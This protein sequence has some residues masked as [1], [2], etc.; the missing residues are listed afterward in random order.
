M[1]ITSKL[2][3]G[4]KGDQ[5]REW[6]KILIK[7]GF[8]LSPWYDDGDFGESTHN[9]TVAWQSSHGLE[10]NGIVGPETVAKINAITIPL[11]DPFSE[12]LNIKFI[13][14]KNYQKA[15][16]NQISL[17]VLHSEEAPESSTTALNVANWFAGNNA[18]MASAHFCLD[19]RNIIQ[20][21]KEE[22][23]AYHAL[24]ANKFSI[25]IEHA[26]Y[27]RQTEEQWADSFSTQMLKRSAKLTASL[28]KKWNI[29]VKYIDV[30]GLINK[31]SGITTHA[32]C[33]KAYKE[34]SHTDPGEHFPIDL[35]ITW[36]QQCFDE[37]I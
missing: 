18:P 7:N 21:V 37:L 31:E 11:S 8:D 36:V 25:G 16:R 1:T 34:G 13:Q 12:D 29:P 30:K 23:V 28:C 14:A 24:S 5:T 35:Y 10:P 32:N 20:C 27:A 2:Q 9:A 4:S 3:L 33:T 26:G 22:D 6:Q 19:D 17:I 15:N